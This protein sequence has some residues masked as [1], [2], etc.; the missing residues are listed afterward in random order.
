M[1]L[2]GVDDGVFAASKVNNDLLGDVRGD[3]DVVVTA[4]E[5]GTDFA[6]DVFVLIRATKADDLQVRLLLTVDHPGDLIE[7]VALIRR[8]LAN[9]SQI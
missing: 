8:V 1:E 5:V 3:D 7:D 4:T 9:I 2:A 6:V